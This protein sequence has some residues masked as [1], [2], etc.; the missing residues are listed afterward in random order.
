MGRWRGAGGGGKG[1]VR[2]QPPAAGEERERDPGGECSS[3]M[4]SPG[5]KLVGALPSATVH[6]SPCV[7]TAA[8]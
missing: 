2:A 5:H 1:E 3:S 7:A 8:V 6:P 4:A